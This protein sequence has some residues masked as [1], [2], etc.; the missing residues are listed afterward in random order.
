MGLYK[1]VRNLWK[2]PKENLGDVWKEH[3]IEWRREP[4]TV[5][6]LRPTRI[7]RAR[8]LGYKAKPG[9]IIVRQKVMRSRRKREDRAGGR[10]PKTSRI[11][12]VVNKNFK[13]I[14]EERANKKFPNLEVLGSYYL[15]EDGNYHWYEIIMVDP[16]NPSIKADKNISWISGSAHKRRVFRGITSSGRVSRGLM[17]KGKGAEKMRPS[18]TANL[19]KRRKMNVRK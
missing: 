4:V 3:L 13:W 16:E 7:D 6:L 12:Q 1:H 2:K 9:F 17:N 10:R 19:K 8:S 15:A 5:R 14:A 11:L 18:M